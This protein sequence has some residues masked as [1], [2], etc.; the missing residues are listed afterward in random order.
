MSL[1]IRIGDRDVVVRSWARASACSPFH[2]PFPHVHVHVPPSGG[3]RFAGD[4]RN[5]GRPQ[6]ACK[7]RRAGGPPWCAF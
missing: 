1:W 3:T 5:R 6:R 7:Q 4:N 2:F